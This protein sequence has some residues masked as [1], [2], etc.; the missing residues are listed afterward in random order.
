MTATD[1]LYFNPFDPEVRAHPYDHYREL[2]AQGRV[3]RNPLGMVVLTRYDDVHHALRDH[4]LSREV[5]KRAKV[6][7][8]SGMDP[9][10]MR[11]SPMRDYSLLNLDP[12][13]HTRLRRLAA[14]AFTPKAIAARRP[15][16][17][18]VTAGLLDAMAA[19]AADGDTLDLVA[20]LAFPLPFVVI[21]E[22]L[23]MPMEDSDRIRSWSHAMTRTLEPMVT[24]EEIEVGNVAVNAMAAYIREVIDDRRT[25]LGTDVLSALIAAE[26]EGDKLTTPE[27]IATVMLLYVAGHETTVNLIG[28]GTLALLRNPDQLAVW[29]ADPGLAQTAVEEL[30]RYDGPVQFTA[31]VVLEPM[32]VVGE[33]VKEGDVVLP[34]VGSAN[35]DPDRYV[36]A[37][38]LHIDRA[39]AASHIAFGGGIHYC[40]GAALARTEAQVAI[41][42]LLARFS[43]IELAAD[44]EWS[45]RITLRGLDSLRLHFS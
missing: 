33:A 12:P 30:L 28:N 20:D 14:Q 11:S 3:H 40:L 4:R 39:E 18:E 44:P 24:P 10:Q 13:D 22:M 5:D 16:I 2:R 35:H 41:G 7:R 25:H 19:R 45:D 8:F 31:R 34:L 27:L 37:D 21:S 23:G 43:H 6:A 9:E 1:T 29:R 17:E 26:E 42:S 32:E 38:E 15:H 36:D